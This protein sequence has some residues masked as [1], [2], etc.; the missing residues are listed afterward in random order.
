MSR[1]KFFCWMIE[2]YKT[3][4]KT[5]NGIRI[6]YVTRAFKNLQNPT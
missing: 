4:N 1:E 6:V 5:S 2:N 3:A